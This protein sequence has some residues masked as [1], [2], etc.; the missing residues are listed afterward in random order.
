MLSSGTNVVALCGLSGWHPIVAMDE[1]DELE[2]NDAMTRS[3]D[4]CPSCSRTGGEGNEVL[5]G[6]ELRSKS[7]DVARHAH[8]PGAVDDVCK[9]ASE[10]TVL[11]I[12]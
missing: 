9:A 12:R 1:I 11:G 3:L 5:H 8:R 4:G 10:E 6:A 7:V 2:A